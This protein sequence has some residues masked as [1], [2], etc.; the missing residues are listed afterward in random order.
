MSY[1]K[2]DGSTSSGIFTVICIVIAFAAGYWTRDMGVK[3]HIS[4]PALERRAK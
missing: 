4:A 2:D 1:H 3:V